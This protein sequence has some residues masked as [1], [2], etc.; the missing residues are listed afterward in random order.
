MPRGMHASEARLNRL[1]AYPNLLKTA[2]PLLARKRFSSLVETAS[3]YKNQTIIQLDFRPNR[4]RVHN[5]TGK[6]KFF[7]SLNLRF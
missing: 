6:G 4:V 2:Y 5:K 7:D 1:P 3:K